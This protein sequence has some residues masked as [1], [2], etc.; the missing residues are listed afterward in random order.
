MSSEITGA[1]SLAHKL[2][3]RCTLVAMFDCLAD[4]AEGDKTP[5]L[6]ILNKPI[7]P[8]N[9]LQVGL[10]LSDSCKYMLC[11][12]LRLVG[13]FRADCPLGVYFHPLH[14]AQTRL[15]NQRHAY[16]Q[17]YQLIPSVQHD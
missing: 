10:D 12:R 5:L 17:C 4:A 13:P 1:R 16:V 9:L 7:G 15:S 6:Q 2:V 3:S 11:A 8:T 14:I